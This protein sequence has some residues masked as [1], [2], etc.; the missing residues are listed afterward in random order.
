MTIKTTSVGSVDVALLLFKDGQKLENKKGQYNIEQFLR[1]FQVFEGMN[2]ATMEATFVLEDA[3]GLLGTLTGSELFVLHIKGQ[4]ADRTYYFRSY[5]ITS[6]SKTNQYTDVYVVQCASEEFLR[7]EVT[8][9]FGNSEKIFK[10]TESSKIIKR[11]VKNDQ[12][13]GS[14]KRVFAEE[15]LNKN[16]F[17]ATNWRPLDAIYWVLNRSIRKSSVGGVVQNGFAFFE[18]ALGYHFKSIDQLIED[19]NDQTDDKTRP[20]K[21]TA[22]LYT[23][24]YSQKNLTEDG[25][26]DMYKI[27]QVVFPKEKSVL[28]GLRQGSWAGFSVGFD[29]VSITSSKIGGTKD[30]PIAAYQYSLNDMWKNMSH[31]A[32]KNSENPISI[33]DQEVAQYTSFPRR[34]RYDLFPNQVFDIKYQNKPGKNYSDLVELQA[35]QWM[36]IESLKS[37]KL[38]VTVPGNL[39]LYAGY[40]INII[41]PDTG[42]SGKTTKVD[43]K[44]SGR[45]IIAGLTHRSSNG[46]MSTEMLLLKDSLSKK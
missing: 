13:L 1:E 44:Y 17:I 37:I 2:S 15:C 27:D 41:I 30:T 25:V 18:N 9:V 32:G 6:R 38:L 12:Y 42:K 46:R 26:G 24:I 20:I 33:L 28:E 8:N 40:G 19:I 3:G 5:E 16:K 21:G 11:L 31:L 34:T 14:K 10:D 23:Y 45:Y 36:R 29:P 22:K 35:Y 39:D 7:N 4:I 43:R